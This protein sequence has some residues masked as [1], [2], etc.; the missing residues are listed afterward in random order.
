MKK[1]KQKDIEVDTRVPPLRGWGWSGRK[2]EARERGQFLSSK[3]LIF[4]FLVCFRARR[5]STGTRR[6]FRE[7]MRRRDQARVQWEL[8]VARGNS[9]PES[10]DVERG[11]P[12]TTGDGR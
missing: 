5:S 6:V 7:R 9:V 8:F 4:V 12:D 10:I 3:L 2:R 11:G 1:R